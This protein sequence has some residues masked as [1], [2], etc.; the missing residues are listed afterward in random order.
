MITIRERSR[1]GQNSCSGTKGKDHNIMYVIDMTRTRL[2]L[3]SE[4]DE[5]MDKASGRHSEEMMI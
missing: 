2:M 4:V 3:T 1:T 5:T